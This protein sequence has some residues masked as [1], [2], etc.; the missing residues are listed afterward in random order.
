MVRSLANRTFQLRSAHA[1]ALLKQG[2]EDGIAV[3]RVSM[4]VFWDLAAETK[5][6]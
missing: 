4:R 5:S 3:V 2:L 1:F 6:S